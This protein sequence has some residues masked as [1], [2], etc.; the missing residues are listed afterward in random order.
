MGT[1]R[2]IDSKT[3]VTLFEVPMI[4]VGLGTLGRWFID[5]GMRKGT[6]V[7]LLTTTR[8][9]SREPALTITSSRSTEARATGSNGSPIRQRMKTMP[10]WSSST[11]RASCGGS[12]T[13]DSTPLG[14]TS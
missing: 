10:T 11:G 1:G 3:D 14:P 2:A 9:I 8:H 12:I 5:R 6:P 7:E 4:M 13:A